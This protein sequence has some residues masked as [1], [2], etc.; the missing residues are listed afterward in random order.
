[1]KSILSQFVPRGVSLRPTVSMMVALTMVMATNV[2]SASQLSDQTPKEE[3]GSQKFRVLVQIQ[4]GDFACVDAHEGPFGRHIP[5]RIFFRPMS[6]NTGWWWNKITD[7]DQRVTRI[8][9]FQKKLPASETCADYRMELPQSNE[10]FHFERL[11]TGNSGLAQNGRQTGQLVETVNLIISPKLTL[12]G[13]FQWIDWSI[14][15]VDFNPNRRFK[16]SFI[17]EFAAVQ[18]DLHVK[19]TAQ[20]GLHCK[21]IENRINLAFGVDPSDNG[22]DIILR[23]VYATQSEC[24]DAL[25][26]I[27]QALEARGRSWLGLVLPA[28]RKLYTTTRNAGTD[29]CDTVRVERVETEIEGVKFIGTN[30]IPVSTVFGDCRN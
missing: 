26:D 3:M 24:M 14:P 7:Y 19:T 8:Q 15:L 29:Q 23:R 28:K 2:A 9:E 25:T 4:P 17:N 16:D 21:A 10:Y 12:N 30:F 27:T 18:R 1:M 11:I 22:N 13:E 5:A 20:S 6:G